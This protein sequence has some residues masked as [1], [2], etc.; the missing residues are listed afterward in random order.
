MLFLFIPDSSLCC[1][2]V[3]CSVATVHNQDQ[4]AVFILL[5]SFL[6]EASLLIKAS[7]INHLEVYILLHYSLDVSITFG[8]TKKLHT[9]FHVCNNKG[10]SES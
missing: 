9:Y 10:L 6:S 8:S 3:P 2:I 4:D 5:S 1:S 7:V